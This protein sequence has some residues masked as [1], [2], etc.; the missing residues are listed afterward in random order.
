[1]EW[2]PGYMVCCYRVVKFNMVQN[3]YMIS[4]KR[5]FIYITR[6]NRVKKTRIRT[7]INI[8]F[9]EKNK[10]C[11]KLKCTRGYSVVDSKVKKTMAY[12]NFRRIESESH[13]F[14]QNNE[15]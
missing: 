11:T 14:I 8:R 5:V 9:Q 6:Y 1:M 13:D 15:R 3:K 4:I 12:V 10:S 7:D 2:V